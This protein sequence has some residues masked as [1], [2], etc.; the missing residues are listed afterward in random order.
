MVLKIHFL[1][2]VPLR[3]KDVTN[4]HVMKKAFSCIRRRIRWYYIT[5]D[6][7]TPPHQNGI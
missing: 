7:E 2:T 6:P 3:L 1:E 4:L 5:V